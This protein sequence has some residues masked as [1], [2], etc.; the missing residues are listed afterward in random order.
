[1]WCFECTTCYRNGIFCTRRSEA[2]ARATTSQA[3]SPRR[4][5]EGG[6][7]S[8]GSAGVYADEARGLDLTSI[9]GYFAL[10]GRSPDAEES[11]RLAC[12]LS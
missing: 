8:A 1:V 3:G 6:K 4:K 9:G 10:S 11:T 12:G 7:P 5:G 2:A